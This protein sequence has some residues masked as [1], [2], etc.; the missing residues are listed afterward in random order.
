VRHSEYLVELDY[1]FVP[2]PGIKI[3]PNV[4]WGID[5]GGVAER[6]NV[7]ALGIKTSLTF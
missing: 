1:R 4:Q 5:P 7:L 3:A 2:I 6:E